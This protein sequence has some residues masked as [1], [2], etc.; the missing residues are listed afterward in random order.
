MVEDTQISPGYMSSMWKF[1]ASVK[2]TVM[3][4]LSLAV[5]SSIG[6]LI[7]QNQ[8]PEEYFRA[9]GPFRYQVL[10]T[11][12]IFD[13]YHSWWFQ[14]LI[15]LLVVNIVICS[16]DRLR[17]TA[18]I[19]F[20]KKPTFNLNSF[21]RRKAR[22]DF[23]IN[24]DSGTVRETYRSILAKHFGY[25][26]VVDTGMGFAVTAEKG[27]WTRLGVYGVHLSVVL[28][29]IG[30]LIGSLLGFEGFA[31]IAVGETVSTIRM[32]N[33]HLTKTLPFA[34]RCDDFEVQ[35]YDTGAPKLFRSDLVLLEDGQPVVEKSIIV[36]DP[37][38][39]KGI[40]I[41]QS[42]YGELGQPGGAAELPERIELQFVST[43][44]GMVYTKSVK[45]EQPVEIPEGLGRFTIRDYQPTAKFMEMAIGPTIIGTLETKDGTEQQLMLPIKFPKFDTMRRGSVIISVAK[46]FSAAGQAYFTG[47]QITHDPGVVIVYIGFILMIAGCIVAFFMSHQ[48][49]VVEVLPDG[50]GAKV[51][52]AG[53]ANKNKFGFEQK[54]ERLTEKLVGTDVG[55]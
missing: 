30:G 44:S 43:A 40:N 11:L 16:I 36:N 27:R 47:L 22:K 55:S 7:P 13:M 3:V 52:V 9:F 6:T 42:S 32:R 21:R 1:F 17:I 39:Y 51:M 2:L 34:I 33:S 15:L 26:A 50:S 28:L 35:F 4:L 10:S 49:I 38:R 41:F 54:L 19:I 31:N 23:T 37:L 29:L 18:K 48:R 20:V 12:D 46:E 14:F 24:V 53:T 5:L 8:S 45:A 25:C